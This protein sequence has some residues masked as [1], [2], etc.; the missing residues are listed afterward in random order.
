MRST[1]VLIDILIHL[2]PIFQTKMTLVLP[3]PEQRVFI[4]KELNDD[5]KT[6]DQDVEHIKE[7]LLKQPHLPDTWGMYTSFLNLKNT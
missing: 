6:R 1:S 4:W 5:V 3:T 7:W 2:Q